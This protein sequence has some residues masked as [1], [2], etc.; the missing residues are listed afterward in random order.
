MAKEAFRNPHVENLRRSFWD[1][2]LWKLGRYNEKE[3]REKMPDSFVYPVKPKPFADEG[4]SALWI[5]HSTYLIEMNGVNILTDPIWSKYC[6]P[7]PIWSLKRRSKVPISLSDLPPIDVVLISHNHYDHLDAKSIK[8]LHRLYP[9]I[10]WVVA[11]GLKGWFLKRGISRCEELGWWEKIPI[12]NGEVQAVPAQHFSGRSLWDNNRTLWCGFVV[13]IEGK[14]LYFSGDTGYN[15][16]DFV[17]IGKKLGPMDLSLI[18][19]GTYIPKGFMSSVHISPFEA[20]KIHREVRSSFSLGM[21]WATFHLSDEPIQRPPFDLYLAMK[22]E[23]LALDSFL[24]I[25]IGLYVHF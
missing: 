12:K 23:G 10:Q 17:E 2:I 15:P 19:I 3:P 14:K 21:H 5:G 20:V 9:D 6:S 8:M 24:P 4:Y 22:K 11:K 13:E 16:F 7:L 25:E 1:F 18:P